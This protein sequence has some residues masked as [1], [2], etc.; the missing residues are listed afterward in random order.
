VPRT[1]SGVFPFSETECQIRPVSL[2]IYNISPP[3]GVDS[4]GNPS[5]AWPYMASGNYFDTLG[6]QPLLRRF[7][8]ASDEQGTGSAPYEEIRILALIVKGCKNREIA[9][10]LKSSQQVIKNYL[11]SIY[12]KTG[13][14]ERLELALFTIH[15]HVLAQVA[16][17]MGERIE[18]E[19][20]QALPIAAD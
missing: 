14:S 6:I 13:V 11:C 7:F 19:E 17:E 2:A 12:N 5:V 16:G 10:R 20:R 1:H 4:G 15:H 3:V 18:A 9:I 8:H